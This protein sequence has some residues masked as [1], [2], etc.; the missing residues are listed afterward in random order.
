MNYVS[1]PLVEVNNI[2]DLHI[3]RFNE[4]VIVV[5]EH[6]SLSLPLS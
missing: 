1:E 6:K 4:E 3:P 2:K 5:N